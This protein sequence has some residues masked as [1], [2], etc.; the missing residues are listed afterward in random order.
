MCPTNP[1]DWGSLLPRLACKWWYR[2]PCW[3]KGLNRTE[4]QGHHVVQ[5]V[6]VGIVEAT[7][8]ASGESLGRGTDEHARREGDA[9]LGNR[10]RQMKANVEREP[11]GEGLG[12]P[13]AAICQRRVAERICE[14][15]S[16]LLRLV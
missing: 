4:K 9:L 11:L 3:G 6:V 5:E 2:L 1:A 16:D 10:L 14:Q 8:D 12:H 7:L 15:Q 13:L